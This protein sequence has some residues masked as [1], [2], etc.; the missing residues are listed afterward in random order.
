MWLDTI[1]KHEVEIRQG[2]NALGVITD[3]RAAKW[4]GCN[5]LFKKG[6]YECLTHMFGFD[7]CT[8]ALT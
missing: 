3:L 2:A 1:V 5:R 8:I 6:D 7:A 4:D